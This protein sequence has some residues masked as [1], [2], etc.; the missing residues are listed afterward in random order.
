[1]SC[2][3]SLKKMEYHFF[4][5]TKTICFI[6]ILYRDSWPVSKSNTNRCTSISYKE[7]CFFYLNIQGKSITKIWQEIF[8]TVQSIYIA[9]THDF[10]FVIFISDIIQRNR[11]FTK[12]VCLLY[13]RL[14]LLL[15]LL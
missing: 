3:M 13:L 9:I 15:V 6:I 11:Q 8:C 2:K 4:R 1:M 7:S 10:M 5:I 12:K 14:L